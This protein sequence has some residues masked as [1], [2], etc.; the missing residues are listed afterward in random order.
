M[1]EAQKP[2]AATVRDLLEAP[3]ESLRLRLVAGGRGLGNPITSPR[4]QKPGLALTGFVQY[5]RPGRVQ[6]LGKS[7]V[8][9]LAELSPERRG[10]VL[11]DLCSTPMT[12]IVLTTG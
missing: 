12:C 9:Y 5:V 11:S 3:A 8:A 10:Q 6:V 2:P 4:I 7:E 1:P